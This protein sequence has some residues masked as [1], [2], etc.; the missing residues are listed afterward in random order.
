M[1]S[2]TYGGSQTLDRAEYWKQSWFYWCY[3]DFGGINKGMTD[4]EV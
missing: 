3:K 1:L 4:E 2:E